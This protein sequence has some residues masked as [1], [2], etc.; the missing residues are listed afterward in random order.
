MFV[1][2]DTTVAITGSAWTSN[3]A[4]TSGGVAYFGSSTVPSASVAAALAA[5]TAT[6]SGVPAG[7]PSTGNTATRWGPVYGRNITSLQVVAPVNA[8]PGVPFQATATLIDGFGQPVFGLSG[9]VLSAQLQTGT[10]GG[11][12][13][14]GT[15]RA[16]YDTA[17]SSLSPILRGPE[18][19]AFSLLFQVDAVPTLPVPITGLASVTISTCSHLE[20]FDS[21]SSSCVCVGNSTR[22]ATLTTTCRCVLAR[23]STATPSRQPASSACSLMVLARGYSQTD[24]CPLCQM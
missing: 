22:S 6:A 12:S 5:C 23:L 3:A 16:T 20:T 15:V 1:A 8:R 2:D 9:A 11:G 17:N 10:G 14:A 24:L 13:L 21:G 19:A 18:N 7:C 4:G